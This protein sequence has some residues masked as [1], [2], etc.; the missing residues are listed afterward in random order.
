[1]LSMAERLA[2][3]VAALKDIDAIYKVIRDDSPLMLRRL[4]KAIADAEPQ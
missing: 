1:V 3:A 4:A 2:P